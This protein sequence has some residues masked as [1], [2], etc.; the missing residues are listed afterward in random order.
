MRETQGA[1]PLDPSRALPCT[2]EG[3]ST[4]STPFSRLTWSLV[5][6]M[7]AFLSTGYPHFPP[8]PQV[9]AK[10]SNRSV[11]CEG[12]KGAIADVRLFSLPPCRSRRSEIPCDMKNQVAQVK[13]TRQKSASRT[14]V[15]GKNRKFPYRPFYHENPH[16]KSP[17]SPQFLA[18]HVMAH[19]NRAAK[20]HLARL[21]PRCYTISR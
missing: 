8:Y 4:L 12:V 21:Q 16:L 20:A 10:T 18:K 7:P 15:M 6:A 17:K 9:T 1:L 3:Y 2:R 19:Q 13:N 14:E 5:Q 11:H